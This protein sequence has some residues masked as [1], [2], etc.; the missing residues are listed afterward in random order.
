MTSSGSNPTNSAT[1]SR[2][3]HTNGLQMNLGASQVDSDSRLRLQ[4]ANCFQQRVQLLFLDYQV[5]A[6]CFSSIFQIHLLSGR[7]WLWRSAAS[8]LL[9]SGSNRRGGG[10]SMLSGARPIR[11]PSNFALRIPARPRSTI[12]LFTNSAI[13][14]TI[15]TIARPSGPPVSMFS[16][17]LTN[18]M[19]RAS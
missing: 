13:A 19:L 9:P 3:F 6:R 16:R 4:P 11:L 10:R 1:K 12:K 14:P 7:Q 5:A 15:T 17:K 18:S 8:S 2:A